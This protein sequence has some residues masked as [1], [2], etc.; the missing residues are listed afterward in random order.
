[1]KGLLRILGATSILSI[2]PVSSLLA[3]AEN[4][5]E[6]ATNI[7]GPMSVLT[8]LV[9]AACY[10]VGIAL[11]VGGI[12]QYRLHRLN[13]KQ[14]PL[15]KPFFYWLMGIIVFLLPYFSHE[16]KSWSLAKQ[17]KPETHYAPPAVSEENNNDDYYGE[18]KDLLQ[19]DLQEELAPH[20]WSVDPSN[21]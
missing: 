8:D 15:T 1:M 2:L 20:H 12:M 19:E 5:G 13:A 14:V 17:F 7:S 6:L 16:S 11:F 9:L 3:K 21:F 4:F 10:V 18:S